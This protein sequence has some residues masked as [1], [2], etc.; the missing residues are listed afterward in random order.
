MES[1]AALLKNIL[2]KKLTS[3]QSA[4]A[5][6][7]VVSIRILS[8]NAI[9]TIVEG[10]T[11]ICIGTE[12]NLVYED[13]W[14][15]GTK[16]IIFRGTYTFSNEINAVSASIKDIDKRRRRDQIMHLLNIKMKNL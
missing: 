10:H 14:L 9:L 15:A 6:I 1:K 11:N 2:E 5:M 4:E 8:L 12:D 13:F 7:D 16:L 3:L